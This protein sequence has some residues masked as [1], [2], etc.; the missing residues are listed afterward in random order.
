MSMAINALS[1]WEDTT[2]IAELKKYGD[3]NL[4][5][6]HDE[7]VDRFIRFSWKGKT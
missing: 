6:T 4:P 1:L 3:L 7:S 5:R 2:L